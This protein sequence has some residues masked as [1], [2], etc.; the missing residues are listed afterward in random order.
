MLSHGLVRKPI[1]YLGSQG[2]RAATH[3]E[4]AL[5]FCAAAQ[6]ALRFGVQTLD[7]LALRGAHQV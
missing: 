6:L 4:D 7:N 2:D 1:P 5:E 3:K